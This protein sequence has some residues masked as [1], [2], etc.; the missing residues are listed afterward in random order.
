MPVNRG[1]A[2]QRHDQ[3]ASA[4]QSPTA[5][6]PNS[7]ELLSIE[8]R[9]LVGGSEESGY[10]LAYAQLTVLLI[11]AVKELSIRVKELEAK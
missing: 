10:G 2:A 4:T 5:T 11:N 7:K 1:S 6:I 8:G 3:V 9:G